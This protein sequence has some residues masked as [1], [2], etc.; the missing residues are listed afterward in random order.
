[1]WTLKCHSDRNKVQTSTESSQ[2]LLYKAKKWLRTQLSYKNKIM[3]IVRLKIQCL[4]VSVTHLYKSP[5][6]LAKASQP[7]EEKDETIW[8]SLNRS[9][10]SSSREQCEVTKLPSSCAGFGR[11]PGGWD[12]NLWL[13]IASCRFRP[14][15]ISGWYLPLSDGRG[16][17]ERGGRGRRK[18]KMQIERQM[19][20]KKESMKEREREREKEREW[21]RER[22]RKREREKCGRGSV[23]GKLLG[24]DTRK[25]A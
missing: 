11:I 7:N 6:Y 13:T 5:R 17:V 1:M 25:K 24:I 21:E 20:R 19:D 4:N 2:S 14:P 9:R 3:H 10:S 23:W 12:A 15:I 16:W 22:E 8:V 18:L